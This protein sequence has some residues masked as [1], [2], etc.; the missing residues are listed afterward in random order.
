MGND[1]ISLKDFCHH[2]QYPQLLYFSVNEVFA[3]FVYF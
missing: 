2:D 3:L 1:Y